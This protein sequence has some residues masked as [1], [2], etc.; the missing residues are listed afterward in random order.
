M[1]PEGRYED[2]LLSWLKETLAEYELPIHDFTHSFAD[3]RIL[4]AL[5]HKYDESFV[6]YDNVDSSKKS[7]NVTQA[8]NTAEEKIQIPQLLDAATVAA[9]EADERSMV[10][11]VSLVQNAFAAK[12]RMGELENTKTG[13]SSK[14]SQLQAQL[15]ASE[16]EKAE[17]A[18]K[19]D[20]LQKQ[21]D[22]LKAK[23]QEQID[24]NEE[25]RKKSASTID[26][27]VT[28]EPLDL[29]NSLFTC[30]RCFGGRERRAEKV[31]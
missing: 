24:I 10:L 30:R 5:L 28:I 13:F 9:G 3:G 16:S 21:L 31:W 29:I 23:L 22:E 2:V 4:L 15:E 7:E 8:F 26:N 27:C 19:A 18:S 14:M 17:F 12:A 1:Y 25:L 20:S 11:Y 6:E